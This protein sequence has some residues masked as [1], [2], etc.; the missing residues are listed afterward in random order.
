MD[1]YTKFVL[2][3]IAV[4]MIGLNIHFFKDEIIS[5]AHAIESH[6]HNAYEIYG[7]EDHEH[8]VRHSHDVS[9]IY[10]FENH[11]HNAREINGFDSKVGDAVNSACSVNYG[12]ISC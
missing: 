5:P 4:A 7:L 12:I 10:G 1:K 8:S 6:K 3:V 11:E 2:T 9:A